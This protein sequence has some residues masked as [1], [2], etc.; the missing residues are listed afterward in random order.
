MLRSNFRH[1]WTALLC[2]LLAAPATAQQ[3]TSKVTLDASETLFS[4]IAGISH[5]GYAPNAG[6]PQ[7]QEVLAEIT[8]AVGKSEQ[9][10]T[11]SREL[12]V[13]YADHRQADPNLDLAQYVSLALSM[14]DAPK[15]DL[16]VK[17]A[18]V[19]PDA[20][21]VL[22]FRP[23]LVEFAKSVGLHEIWL[24]HQHE[25]DTLIEAYHT[26]VTNM[27]L[28]TDI[29]LRLPMSSYLGRAFTVYVEPMEAP[30]P[31]NA[32]NY[33][34]DYFLTVS[35]TAANLRLDDIR[36]TYLHFMI[37][38]L[39]RKRANTMRRLQPLLTTIA[40]A[41]LG[42]EYKHDIALL[43]E[44]SLIR[45]I[46]ARLA[47]KNQKDE[48]PREAE[49]GKAMAEGYI[50]SR[51]FFEQLIKFETDATGFQDALGDFLYNL[52][53]DH[54][55]KR[56][57]AQQFTTRAA[58]EVLAQTKAA[59]GP[60]EMA[61]QRF[62]AGDYDTARALAQ[63]TLDD[64]SGDAGRALFLLAQLAL[65]RDIE[66]AKSYFAKAIEASKDPHIVAWSHIYLGRIAD[67]QGERDT[68]LTHYKAAL[69]A[70]D[71]QPQTKQAAER[72]I[73]KAYEPPRSAKKK[74]SD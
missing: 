71:A 44:E 25:Y 62:A 54:E 45:A 20:N 66:G 38:P 65:N 2:A 7:R 70:G 28:A 19:P 39:I 40:S 4:V 34:A 15:F 14:G 6:T 5:C 10:K 57:L 9:A 30:G 13:F 56:A 63:Q 60:L 32:R 21:Y 36:H 16:K 53:V 22:G 46:E 47:G 68:A 12:C 35:P 33:G 61:E 48:A 43:T 26:P 52:D 31:V 42:D 8:V 73:S 3:T 50:L 51:Y 29:Y 1:V 41:P 59:P 17:E 58:P 67:I 27:L 23:L 37:D 49:I 55:K 18:D 74:E 69:G 24:K 11:D 64:K 72:G